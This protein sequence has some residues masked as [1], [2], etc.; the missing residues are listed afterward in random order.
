MSLANP[1][2]LQ[3]ARL[4][5][6]DLQE[7]LESRCR[8]IQAIDPAV[9]GP[10]LQAHGNDINLLFTSA[11]T[12]TPRE[13]IDRLPN[14]KAI[15]SMGVG[16]DA[17]DVRYAQSRGIPV[18]NTPD[19]LNEC[20]ADTAFALLLA[21]ARGIAHGDRFIR[22]NQWES[23]QSFPFTTSV[24]GKK[25]G[26]AGLGRIGMAIARRAEA[27]GMDIHYHNRRQRSD[28]SY[29]YEP[30]LKGLAEW[31]D[32]LVIATVGGA[33]TRHLVNADVLRALGPTGRL[34]N[35]SRGSV[36][37]ETALVQALQNGELGGAGLDVFENEPHVPD[38]LKTMDNVV[39]APHVGSATRETRHDMLELTVDNLIRYIDTGRM[40]TPIAPL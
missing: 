31:A 28:T 16:F 8:V 23:G 22:H 17:I 12:P 5:F 3:I 15:S 35:I 11:T 13:L 21:C 36:V 18:S 32:F 6:P 1:V 10:L 30:T 40:I 7:K 25:L 14:L 4:P 37:D 24:H 2:V 19:V 9:R 26:I 29:G 27:F 20:V 33:E 34:V 38:A 39:L